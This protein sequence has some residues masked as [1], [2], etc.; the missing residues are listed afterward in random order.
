MNDQVRNHESSLTTIAGEIRAEIRDFVNTRVRMIKSEANESLAAIKSAVPLSIAAVSLLCTGALLLS[1]AVVAAVSV[2]FIG[3]PY[4]WFFAF[5]IVGVLWLI[6]GG[7]A[8]LFA[9][10]QFRG[11]FPTRSF[12][13]LKADKV[14]LQSEIKRV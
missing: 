10:N 1:L 11:R 8:A 3:D 4:A 14:W 5:L 9:H 12:Q 7:I 6:L 2:A 13:V